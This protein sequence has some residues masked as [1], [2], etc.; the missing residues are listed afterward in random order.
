MQ[1]Y[2]DR[3]DAHLEADSLLTQSTYDRDAATTSPTLAGVAT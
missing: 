2:F 3:D 1:A